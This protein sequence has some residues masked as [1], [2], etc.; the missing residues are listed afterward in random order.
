LHNNRPAKRSVYE[1]EFSG[2]AQVAVFISLRNLQS[3]A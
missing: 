2:S 3:A 1:P